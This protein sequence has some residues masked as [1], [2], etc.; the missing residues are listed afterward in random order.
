MRKK[1]SALSVLVVE[2]DKDLLGAISQFL[3]IR[4]FV[5][6]ACANAGDAIEATRSTH[7]PFDILL[8]DLKLPD[9]DG[10]SVLKAAKERHPGTLAAILTG[11]ASLE[12][13]LRSI[14]LGAYDYL[15]KP[16]GLDE[17]EILIRNMSDKIWLVRE[18][19]AIEGKL[20][21]LYRQVETLQNEKLDL[22]RCN[23]D[24][25]QSFDG[26]IRRV[27]KLTDLVR[28]SRQLPAAR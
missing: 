25:K 5:V 8:A 4:G 10:L 1:L 14:R 20:G 22:M 18:N 19:R 28:A 21:Q 11:Y 6:T 27:E 9:G 15:T 12:T 24:L 17:I 16:F 26:L 13:A 7:T 3:Q 23:Q 2:D